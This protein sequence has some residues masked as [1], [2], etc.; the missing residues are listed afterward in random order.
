MTEVNSKETP[1][2]QKDIGSTSKDWELNMHL[3]VLSCWNM[4]NVCCTAL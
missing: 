4:F 1:N 2:Q 3:D